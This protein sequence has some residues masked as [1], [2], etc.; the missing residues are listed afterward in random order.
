MNTNQKEL[1]IKKLIKDF[2]IETT[3]N[4]YEKY[5]GLKEFLSYK[6]DVYVTYLP[7]ENPE[8]IIITSKKIIEEGLNAVPHLPARTFKDYA[9]IEKY[10]GELSEE[11]GCTKI[12]LI[13]GG[14]QIGNIQSSLDVLESGFL[15]KY[16][17]K[18]VGVAGHPEGNPNIS[19]KDL[20]NAI[21]KKNNFS[22]N[23]DFKMYIVT[24][25]FFEAKSFEIWENYLKSLGNQLEI[26][27]GIPGPANIK[28]LFTYAKSCGIG[29][30][31]KFLS[32]QAMNI[33]K[34]ASSTTP[35]KL[36]AELSKYRFS[37][38]NSKLK[39]LHL[40]PFGGIKK[41]SEWLNLI[42]DKPLEIKANNEFKIID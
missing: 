1:N 18:H 41:T 6:N 12:L 25:F 13:G 31:I 26:H 33:T 11:A 20:D 7:D 21:I 4:V 8:R 37:A 34:L 16:K 39:K 22:Q 35:D 3:P 36:I 2:S 40:F 15:S 14:S 10:I 24:Q 27:A 29:N 30:S 32:K 38:S 5:D 42:L 9:M 17:F 23:A 19:K 28:T